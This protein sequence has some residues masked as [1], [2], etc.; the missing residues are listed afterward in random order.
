MVLPW[1]KKKEV[2]MKTRIVQLVPILVFVVVTASL[3]Q[4]QMPIKQLMMRVHIPFAFIAGGA[5]L[6]AGDYVVYHPG[7]P[8]LVVVEKDDGKAR[9]MEYVHPSATEPDASSTKLVFNKYGEQYFLSQVWTEPDRELH[10][11][12]KGRREIQLSAHHQKPKLVLVVAKR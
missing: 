4:A 7:D 3:S 8:Y 2:I 10:Q 11:A 12:F 1:P 6:P 5:H 9:G